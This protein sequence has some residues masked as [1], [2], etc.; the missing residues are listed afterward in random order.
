MTGTSKIAKPICTRPA[1]IF[2]K[3]EAI[4]FATRLFT[5]YSASG[6]STKMFWGKIQE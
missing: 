6:N 2:H 5:G 3:I 4:L 1:F